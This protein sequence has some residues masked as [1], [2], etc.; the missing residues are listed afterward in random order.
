MKRLG[1]TT[2]MFPFGPATM[3]PV[4][5]LLGTDSSVIHTSVVTTEVAR[6]GV[7]TVSTYCPTSKCRPH[8]RAGKFWTPGEAAAANVGAVWEVAPGKKNE[9]V[10]LGAAVG[11]EDW[12]VT[13]TA[14]A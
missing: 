1:P 3:L 5:G 2:L 6:C 10:E 12:F 9:T 13:A 4:A 8:L 7:G 11:V 14:A